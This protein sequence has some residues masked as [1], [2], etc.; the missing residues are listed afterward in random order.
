MM[1]IAE[2]EDTDTPPY[3][4]RREAE[5]RAGSCLDYRRQQICTTAISF[6]TG[7]AWIGQ[8]DHR[9]QQISQTH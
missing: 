3:G 2:E 8:A 6:Y 9:R 4:G 5:I 7:M 1:M